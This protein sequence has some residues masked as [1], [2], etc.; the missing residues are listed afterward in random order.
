[1]KVCSRSYTFKRTQ[2]A[3]VQAYVITSH[4]AQG[5]TREWVIIDY[6]SNLAKHGLFSRLFSRA[7]HQDGIFLKDFKKEYVHYDSRVLEQY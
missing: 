2:L 3:L 7:I 4:S 5:I 6:R 1:M